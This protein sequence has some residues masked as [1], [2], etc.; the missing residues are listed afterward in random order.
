[1]SDYVLRS[2]V[3]GDMAEEKEQAGYSEDLDKI[4]ATMKKRKEDVPGLIALLKSK[5]ILYRRKAADY[6]GEI[7][8]DRAV[9]A[10]IEA[11][12][13][14]SD[15]SWLAARSLGMIGDRR[16]TGPLIEALGSPEKWLRQGAAW[17]LGKI[18]DDK[19]VEPLIPLLK[20]PNK[21]VRKNAAWALGIIGDERV[22]EPLTRIQQDE[23]EG[24]RQAAKV[25]LDAVKKK[26]AMRQ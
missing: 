15:V 2:A 18:G 24:V 11:L 26:I 6:L 7:G 20:D 16:A 23:D 10:L 19:A 13:D 9:P 4:M 14:E 5:N 22:I 17:A 21:D 25:A 12:K 8:D 1:M 3:E